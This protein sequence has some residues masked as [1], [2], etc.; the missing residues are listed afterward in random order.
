MLIVLHLN[1]L[2]I[3]QLQTI[4]TNPLIS[5]VPVI[6]NIEGREWRRLANNNS[7][8]KPEHPRA[9]ST[10]DVECFFSIMRDNIGQNFTMKQ[11][12]YGFHKACLEFTKRIDPDLTFYYHTSSHTRFYEGLLPNFIEASSKSKRKN[13]RVPRREQ[14]A[15][16]APRRASMPVRGSLSLRAQFHNVPVELPPLP[17]RPVHVFDHNYTS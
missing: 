15:A 3:T 17:F 14:P 10:D 12:K 13:R 2:I 8:Q 16:F 9:S 5:N 4:S 7:G 6:A 1:N 11:V